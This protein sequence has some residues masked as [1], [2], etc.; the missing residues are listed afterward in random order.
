MEFSL[1]KVNGRPVVKI[2]LEGV[3]DAERVLI[4]LKGEFPEL[5]R[6][7]HYLKANAPTA[8]DTD[9]SPYVFEDAYDAEDERQL[10]SMVH[11]LHANP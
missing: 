4:A 3:T 10:A 9:P 8:V 2:G 7:V 6:K 1:G 11:Q 5:W